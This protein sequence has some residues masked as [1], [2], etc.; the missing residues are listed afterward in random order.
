[1]EARYFNG[2]IDGSTRPVG[3]SKE[4]TDL[5]HEDGKTIKIR[6]LVVST[7]SLSA[8]VYYDLLPK[9]TNSVKESDRFS[10]MDLD[11]PEGD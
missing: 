9:P 4:Y 6:K 3:F 7:G 11:D 5:L 1:M 10:D 2:I 8:H